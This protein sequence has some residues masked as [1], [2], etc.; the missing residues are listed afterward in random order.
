LQATK[1]GGLWMMRCGADQGLEPRGL[2]KSI[3]V[4]RGNKFR[5][6]LMKRQV[7]S[8]GKTNVTPRTKYFYFKTARW[9][10]AGK[11]PR[12]IINY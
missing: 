3:G 10:L 11:A 2:R 5:F 8:C 9:Q 4:E 12:R 1:S 6:A 7:I